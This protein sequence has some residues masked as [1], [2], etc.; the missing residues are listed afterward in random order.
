M[1]H[2]EMIAVIQAHKDGK[3]IQL[4]HK[5]VHHNDWIDSS[6]PLWNFGNTDYRVKPVPREW[7]VLVTPN[8]LDIRQFG[9]GERGWIKVRE[10]IE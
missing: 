3:K 10:V 9:E 7:V 4:C 1:T 6:N 8:T 2:D 5:P